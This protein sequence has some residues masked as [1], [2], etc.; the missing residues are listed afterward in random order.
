MVCC[1]MVF[2]SSPLCSL[3]FSEEATNVPSTATPTGAPVNAPVG[4]T[5]TKAPVCGPTEVFGLFYCP[6]NSK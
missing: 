2:N 5:A 4:I 3:M 6:D 1:E